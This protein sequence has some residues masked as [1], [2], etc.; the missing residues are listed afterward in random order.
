ML[1]TNLRARGLSL[2]AALPD[3]RIVRGDDI[4]VTSCGT[5]AATCRAGE[6]FVALTTAQGDGHDDVE[7]ALQRGAAAVLT[8]R[9]LPINLPQCIVPDTREALGQVCQQLAGQPTQ[10]LNTIAVAGTQGKTIATLLIASVLEAAK[11]ATGVLSTIGYSDSAEQTTAQETTPA[12]PELAH[13]LGRMVVAG[14]R[15][16]VVEVSRPALAERRLAGTEWDA[17]VLNSLKPSA[18][19]DAGTLVAERQLL[20]RLA[21]QLKTDGFVVANADDANVAAIVDKLAGPVITYGLRTAAEITATVLE[22]CPSE[23][24]SNLASLMKQADDYARRAVGLPDRITESKNAHTGAD[25][26]AMEF[27]LVYPDDK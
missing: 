6:L 10:E 22:R 4:R 19:D 25:G 20:S 9:L 8:E 14:A 18:T 26:G 7:I 27:K 24:I 11:Q 15:H 17:L 2:R 23:D 1:S 13:W 21:S 16:A 3:A 5:H 12:A